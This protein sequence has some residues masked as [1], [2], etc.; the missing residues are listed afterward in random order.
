MVSYC[1]FRSSTADPSL[2][3]FRYPQAGRLNSPIRH[4]RVYAGKLFFFSGDVP[5][6]PVLW[7]AKLELHD[8]QARY[9]PKHRRLPGLPAIYCRRGGFY[10]GC[11]G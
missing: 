8:Q 3:R 10:I 4:A 7:K 11:G 1:S 6:N 2:D 5:R 9:K